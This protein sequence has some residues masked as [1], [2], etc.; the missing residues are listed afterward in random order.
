VWV[1]GVQEMQD[2]AIFFETVERACSK[3]W[4]IIV[5]TAYH[6]EKFEVHVGERGTPASRQSKDSFGTQYSSKPWK[7][8]APR[9]GTRFTRITIY[10]QSD[11]TAK[12]IQPEK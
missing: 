2:F 6:K 12:I 9:D 8:R 4:H 11:E 5:C 1:R 3:G 7:G 10:C